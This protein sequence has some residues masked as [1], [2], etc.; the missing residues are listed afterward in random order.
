MQFHLRH[1]KK[2]HN[3]GKQ[4]LDIDQIAV[5]SGLEPVNAELKMLV[6]L[7]SL[8]LCL[9]S[10]NGMT[11]IIAALVMIVITLHYGRMKLD[12]YCHML[13]IPASFIVLS[14]IVL[15]IN[16]SSDKMGYFAIPIFS[17]Y[18][19]VTKASLKTASLVTI[20]AFCSINCLYMISLS[21][22]IYEIIRVLKKCKVPEIVIELMY[23]IY[24]FVFV[25]LE[26]YHNMKLAAETRLGYINL[27][28]SYQSFFGI[29]SNL[30]VI[31]FKKA[32]RSYDAME[33]RCYDGKLQFIEN[34]KKVTI[35]QIGFTAFYLLVMI[36]ML[37]VE[38]IW[39]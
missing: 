28:R 32:S 26:A 5:T 4:I 22:P 13:L 9:L 34:K 7:S 33:A 8:I 29:S 15:L 25:L 21:T 20:R 17:K 16:I 39:I 31:A 35:K 11:A 14:G 30:L 38:R 27:R 24:R 36:I 23:L 19:S 10:K 37:I 18:L 2:V 6:G 12:N 3:H 1:K